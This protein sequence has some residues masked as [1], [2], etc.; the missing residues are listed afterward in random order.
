MDDF[1]SRNCMGTCAS[2][3]SFQGGPSRPDILISPDVPGVSMLMNPG[4]YW[5]LYLWGGRSYNGGFKP[6]FKRTALCQGGGVASRP[7]VARL[8]L[9]PKISMCVVV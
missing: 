1:S 6:G 3:L 9:C 5:P 2:L 8:V 4:P 7:M